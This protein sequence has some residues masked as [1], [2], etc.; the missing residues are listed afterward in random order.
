M[1]LDIVRWSCAFFQ[2]VPS[3]DPLYRSTEKPKRKG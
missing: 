2:L 3:P 1:R